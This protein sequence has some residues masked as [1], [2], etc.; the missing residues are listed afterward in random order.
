VALQFVPRAFWTA[1]VQST[2]AAPPVPQAVTDDVVQLLLPQ[3][4]LGHDVA[5]QVHAELTH[6]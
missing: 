6:A 5:V 1:A 3:Q 2:H 4:P